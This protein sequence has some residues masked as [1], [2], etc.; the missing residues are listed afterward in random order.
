MKKMIAIATS[1]AM[2]ISFS[3]ETGYVM[4]SEMQNV[5][6]KAA[7]SIVQSKAN[8]LSNASVVL[9]DLYG[10]D[11]LHNYDAV[12]KMDSTNI[13]SI[14]NNG[15]NYSSS[16]INKA[17][18]GNMTT[19]W[20]TGKP[21]ST[22]F[23]N[24]VV[25]Q[26][27]EATTLDR[28]VYAARQD[29]A[30]GKGFAQ[31]FEI[32]S[33]ATDA[34]ND[35]TLVTTGE[36]KGSTGDVTEIKFA[37]TSFKRLKFVFKKANQDWASAAEFSFYKEDK[38]R[39]AMNDLFTDG[40]MSKVVPEYN[41][42]DKI[43]E[44]EEKAKV[45]PLYPMY[46]DQ[47][48]LAKG[49]V[50]GEVQMEGTI[51]QAEQRGD[52]KKHAQQNLRINFGTNNQ[53]TGFVAMPGDVIN[54]YVD[55][56]SADKLPS[57]VF[58]QQEGSWSSWARGV[59][60]RPGK[61]TIT[62][63]DIPTNSA[64]AHDVTKGGTVYIV[65]PYTPEQQGKAPLI[66]FEG[67]QKIPMMTKDTDPEQFK[68]F[69]TEYKERLDADKAAH[70]NVKDRELIDV[71]EMVSDHVIFTGTA[72]EAYNKYIT[73]GNNPMNT[74]TGYDSWMKEIFDFYGLDSSSEIHDPKLI[75]ENIR[76]M[77][78]YGAM[79]AAG[80]HTGIQNGTVG[81]MLSDF[82]ESY[83]GWGLN[84]EIGHRLAMGEREYGEV[85]N[86]M[87]SMLMSVAAD[88]IDTRIPYEDVIYKYVIEENKAVMS[89]QGY[90]AQL[91]AYW[92]LELAHPG[93]W[94]E[95]TRLY[96]ERKVSLTNGDNSKQQYLVEFSSEVLG[97]DLSS[98][99]ARHGFTVNPETKEKL[100]KYPAPQKLWYLNNSVIHYEGTG[101]E[102]KNASIAVGV[103]PNATAKTN[104]LSFSMEKAYK[105]DFLGYE[106][107][108]NDTLVGFTG[109][110][111]FVDRNVDTSINYTYKIVGYDKKLNTLKPV[112]FK[113]FKPALSV[114]DQVTLKL[115][116]EFDPMNYVKAAS[117]QGNDITSEVVVKSNNVDVT[118]KGNY[119]V[120]YEI[121]S[122]GATESKTAQVTVTSDYVYASDLNA[123]S[124]TV[125]WGSL[126][127]DKAPADGII[128]LIRQGLAATYAKGIGVHANSEVVYDI[129]G[130]G[131][132]FFESYIGIDQ[133]MKGKPS[134]ATFEVYVDGEKK[135]NSDVFKASTEHESIKIPVSGAREVKLVTTDANDNGNAS[136]HTVWADAKFTTVSSKPSLR[137]P[138]ELG[139]VKLHGEFD[140]LSGVEAFDAEDGNLIKQV[141]VETNGFSSN[142]PGTYH[143]EYSVTDHDGNTVTKTRTI[144][145]YSSTQFISDVNWESARTDYNVVRKDKSSTN[146]T[147]KLLV[148]GETKEFA[149]GIGTHANSEI[150][151]NIGD[152]NYEY[153]E[154]YIG[155]DRN[156]PEQ[157]N[158]SI[159]FKIVADGTEVYNSGL[160]KFSTEAKLVRIPLKGVQQLK[161]IVS[162]A[163]NGN[164]SDHGD[165]GD[166]KFLIQNS[167]PEL[168]IPTS[169]ST[170][171]GQ[172]IEISADYSAT[173]A[174]DGNLTS[175]IVVTGE[176]SVNFN[177]AGEY[178]I[179]YSVTDRDGNK[180]TKT[181]TIAV[182]DMEDY[183]YLT[184]YD[185]SS[186]Q[187]SYTAPTKDISISAKTLRL[188]DENNREVSYA[189]GI[190]AHSNSTI[191]Y[192]LTDKN[193]DYFTSF[194]GVDRQMYGSVGS[195]TFQVF[196]DGEKK[197][198]SGLMNSRDPQKFIELD[199]NGAKELKLV[200]TD[201]G[202]GNGSDHASWGDTKLHFAN[203]DRIYTVELEQAI[204]EAKA[205]S[206]EG[207]TSESIE[208]F[209]NSVTR[210]EEVL[211]N[212]NAT[213]EEIDVAVIALNTA[214][215]GL[216]QEDLTQVT[217][218][219][220]TYLRDSIKETLG[221]TGELTLGDMYKLTELTVEIGRKDRVQSLEG[222]E[223]AKNLE[224]LNISGHEVTDFSPLK[225]LTNLKN[226]NANPQILEMKELKGPI[227]EVNNIV[228]GV[229]GQKVIPFTAGIRNNRTFKETTFDVNEWAANPDTF[230]IDL[231]NVEKGYYT[232]IMGY[233]VE[234]NIVQLM[235]M[236]DNQ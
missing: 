182:V 51:I 60:L 87:V 199:I 177:R 213:Q 136:D 99:F 37:P 79:Y 93:Y 67:V 180:T 192:D 62:V 202:N 97:M 184:D 119:E 50:N 153:F 166:A 10:K 107:Y 189:R 35:F 86:N 169:V 47:L 226:L 53:P 168:T 52:M 83:P 123:T 157:N 138:E 74:V 57:L 165:F 45:H 194:V 148:G 227:V 38:V 212:K 54:V 70:P 125:G 220:D 105:E 152:T 137:V 178:P 78:P 106:I 82:N 187:N 206:L 116:Q 195:V 133:A 170:K 58:S 124:A 25:F 102:N 126:K 12:Y 223:Y 160:M 216:N 128:T 218:I 15:G 75:R 129:E 43:N 118:N 229:D 155:V 103:I 190:G 127:K 80:D 167:V 48:E 151:Y 120:V 40:T 61:N 39:D 222:L 158:S 230:T 171:V 161:L 145:V 236:I 44:L 114:E 56:D 179:T 132:D 159:I 24:E 172:P 176:D 225:D 109:T 111:Q 235:Y 101:I 174:E 96:R 14:T 144:V 183:Q 110:D 134:S 13:T 55:V 121:K 130:K 6:A 85:T 100:D 198:D 146:S 11:I 30:K 32:Y 232:F 181:R 68:V 224:T 4:A 140:M 77:Q 42:V 29:G 201:G 208:I 98:Y 49:L 117:Y 94:T 3:S 9:F 17:I 205:I 204:Q 19:H 64:Y 23:T 63:P 46:K 135:F 73:Q 84:H 91:G 228:T 69:L 221:V 59:Q 1:A 95:L 233:T 8:V 76:L 90:F 149:K 31:E 164:A 197:F 66:R 72:T 112:Q 175:Q 196:V 219:E 88:S 41:Q 163:G 173:D 81:T 203:A 92:Q 154:T 142:K 113:A 18:D 22:T 186:T 16:Q 207:Y 217:V 108:R 71:V 26:L 2:I 27:N 36:Y 5:N 214:K 231:T 7:K 210:A 215:E 33:S 34:G 131:Y 234:G 188:T 191:V 21:N 141:E 209:M 143:V 89:E 150:V 193:F 28:M 139:A 185:W 104:T 211:A 65:N 156:I 147:I 115:N 122:G 200:V 20:E 162:D